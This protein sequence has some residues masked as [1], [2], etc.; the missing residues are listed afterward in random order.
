MEVHIEF[1]DD[2]VLH[3]QEVTL[4]VVNDNV[5]EIDQKWGG[6]AHT[7]YFPLVNI[8]RWRTMHDDD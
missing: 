7:E 5:L 1:M 2:T 6:Y 4:L 8:K 3:K